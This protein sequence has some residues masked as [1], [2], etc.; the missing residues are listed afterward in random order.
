MHVKHVVW[1]RVYMYMQRGLSKR[2]HRYRLIEGIDILCACIGRGGNWYCIY[3]MYNCR[4]WMNKS[5]SNVRG[6]EG[7]EK[8]SKFRWA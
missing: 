5:I 3:I 2:K 7:A 1:D 4:V 6:W 8:R